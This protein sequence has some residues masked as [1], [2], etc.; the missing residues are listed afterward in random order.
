M[1]P[2]AAL[3]PTNSFIFRPSFPRFISPSLYFPPSSSFAFS[4]WL[5]ASTAPRC[6]FLFCF[7]FVLTPHFHSSALVPPSFAFPACARPPKQRPHP[8]PRSAKQC[9]LPRS[10]G[11]VRTNTRRLCGPVWNGPV[12][13]GGPMRRI[14]G[15]RWKQST[16]GGARMWSAESAT[17]GTTDAVSKARRTQLNCAHSRPAARTATTHPLRNSRPPSPTCRTRVCAAA[18][19][20]HLFAVRS[21]LPLASATLVCSHSLA[22]SSKA[23][24]PVTW[25]T[26]STRRRQ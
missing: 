26:L 25:K 19:V 22:A 2:I 24:S 10:G 7:S 13:V 1:K 5:L 18:A 8:Q 4:R 11:K 9:L 16:Q 17:G 14:R 3:A 12:A 20:S 6:F 15:R 23:R 21:S